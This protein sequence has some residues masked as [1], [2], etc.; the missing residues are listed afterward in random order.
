MAKKEIR[1][2]LVSM[3]IRESKEQWVLQVEV[4]RRETRANLDKMDHLG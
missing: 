1:A 2:F 3:A 4:D